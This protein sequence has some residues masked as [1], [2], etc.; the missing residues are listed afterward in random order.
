MSPRWVGSGWT[1]FNNKGKPVRQFEPFFDDTHRFKFANI[2]GVSPILF[3]DPVERVVATLHPNHSWEKVVFGPWGQATFD[4]NDTV[5]LNPG[6][7]DDVKGFFSN[8]DGTP[9]IPSSEYLPTWHELRTEPS[10]AAEFAEHYSEVVDRSNETSA[11]EKAAAHADTPTAVYFDTLGRPFLTVA[12]NKVVCRDHAL[13]GTEAELHTR[14]VRDIEGNQRTVTDARDRIV[15]RYGYDMLG[16]RIHQASMEAGERW[17]LNDV[18]GKPIRA[19][20]SRHH[21][22]R[23]SYDRVRRPVESFLKE[24]TEPEIQIGRIIYGEGSGSAGNHRTRIIQVFDNAGIVTNEVYDF[25]GNLEQSKREL[26]P[27]Y[28]SDVN[29]KNN[30]VPNDGS[31]TSSTEY[32]ALN[33][34]VVATAPDGSLYRPTY[35]EAN[36]LN[37]V[38]VNLRGATAVTHFV[39]DIDYDAKGQ[40]K[41]IAYD[42]GATTRYDYDPL[43]FR[44]VH[45]ETARPAGRNGLASQLFANPSI[46][47]DL[48]YTYDLVGNITSIRDE[49]LPTIPHAGQ[50]VDPSADYIYDAVYRLIFA[51]GREHIGQ[52]TFD[53]HPPAG[54][55]RDYPFMG[56]RAPTSEPKAVRNY[57]EYYVYDPVGNFELLR[58][59]AN[60]GSWTQACDYEED[61][62]IEPG[63]KSNRLT[64]TT[65]GNGLTHVAPYT[66]DAHGNMTSMPHLP[67][68]EWDFK[69]QL[70]VTQQ[71]N[72]VPG[73]I[74]EK[75][76]YVYDASGQRVRKVTERQNGTRKNE[77]LYLGGFEIYREYN[78]TGTAT[79]KI[80]R[81]TLHIM[82][83]KQRIALVETRTQGSD[84]GPGQLIR[85]QL[86]N[87]LGSAVLELDDASEVISYEE[88]YPYGSTSYQASRGQT[89]APKRYRYTV[90]ERDEESGL[91]YHGARYYAPWLGRWTRTDPVG[92]AD[93][94][95]LYVFVRANPI[96][97][98]DPTGRYSWGEFGSDAWEGI[99]GVPKGIIEPALLVVDFGQMGATL[100]AHA[101]SDDV[102]DVEWLS[103]TGSSIQ[104]GMSGLR[105]GAVLA[106]AIPTG[107]GSVLLNNIFT[108][109]EGDVMGPSAARNLLV[110]GAVSQTVSTGL[111]M[112]VS[113]YTGNGWTGRGPVPTPESNPTTSNPGLTPESNPS[114][115]NPAP[116]PPSSTAPP[117]LH[118]GQQGK[119]IPGHNN[120]TPGR[121]PLT[122]PDPQGLLN[123][124]AGKGDP[125]G[126]IPRGQPGFKER[127]DFGQIIGEIEGQ[128]TTKGIVHYSNKGAHIVPARPGPDS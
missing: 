54:N 1:I 87:H 46:L 61:S 100:V 95:N 122:H 11:A 53:F 69:D 82:D 98:I 112:G 35:N 29:W 108:V 38:D 92:L 6:T 109:Y 113:S 15:M 17:M 47:Q 48:H 76:Y 66:H 110:R 45:L 89:E 10:H 55:Y 51:H 120:Y 128:P 24:A 91:Y 52:S 88:Y 96:K 57:R 71:Q 56:H 104:A 105:A 65:I 119:H 72:V 20:D 83:D 70:H 33:R 43:T 84:P 2:I 5:T 59:S 8:P 32:D 99:K 106:T 60:G 31:F 63:K 21:E 93:G 34:P 58:H 18:T 103:A 97:L 73:T 9:R 13:D 81:E 125:V 41:M 123:D 26:L 127:I 14:T 16:N 107:G 50:N 85:Y 62:L 80:E 25:K 74:G 28:K 22:F 67:I 30:P 40:R 27:D 102:P 90:K 19:W 79:P 36:L 44:L 12:H 3:Y 94:E 111:A 78:G 124:F 49:A 42:N 7:D 68:M 118:M 86:G 77:R 75:T 126:N 121:S 64:R 23:T 37:K 115:S 117:K 101:V 116:T 114:T 39:T 4:V